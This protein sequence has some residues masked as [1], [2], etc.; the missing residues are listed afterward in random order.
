MWLSDAT[1]F[2]EVQSRNNLFVEYICTTHLMLMPSSGSAN[3]IVT[4][5]STSMQRF[6]ISLPNVV[7]V[8][9]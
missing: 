3:D 9:R 1:Q 5:G 4:L 7:L 8:S 6:F 2:L